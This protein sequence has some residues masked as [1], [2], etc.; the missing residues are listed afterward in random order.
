MSELSSIARKMAQA[1]AGSDQI[2]TWCTDN[3]GKDCQVFIGLDARKPPGV[4]DAPFILVRAPRYDGGLEAEAENYTVMIDWG[5][6]EP[7]VETESGITEY[8]G[9]KM[10]DALGALVLETAYQVSDQYTP[11]LSEYEIESESFFPLIAGGA[12]LIY[13]VPYIVGIDA[14]GI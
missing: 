1:L 12:T 8:T 5:L 3:Y 11:A 2:Q 10:A 7:N 9:H 13:S 6:N 4:K 14:P